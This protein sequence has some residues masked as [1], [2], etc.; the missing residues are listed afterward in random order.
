M[1]EGN[2]ISD[3]ME[4][5]MFG[6]IKALLVVHKRLLHELTSN[7][8]D[9]DGNDHFEDVSIG[10]IFKSYIPFLK[11]SSPILS[12]ISRYTDYIRCQKNFNSVYAR[13]MKDK[14]IK[15]FLDQC[16]LDP[17]CNGLNLS[18]CKVYF[19]LTCRAF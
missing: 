11:L 19:L 18:V 12:I 2:I 5:I 16:L 8:Y 6:N 1:K 3:N 15:A 13:I 17:R 10:G 7:C 4:Y 9:I 14:R